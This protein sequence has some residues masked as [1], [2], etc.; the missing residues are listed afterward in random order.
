MYVTPIRLD[1]LFNTNQ[2]SCRKG[3]WYVRRTDPD[4]IDNGHI[5]S[6]VKHEEVFVYWVLLVRLRILWADLILISS[7]IISQRN[8]GSVWDINASMR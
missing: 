6:S 5:Y 1:L 8:I 4:T 2:I 7:W 3:K